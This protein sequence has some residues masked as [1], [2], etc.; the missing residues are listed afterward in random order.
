[1]W[2]TYY[3]SRTT[4]P[5]WLLD[6]I[7]VFTTKWHPCTWRTNR[8]R[9]R[10]CMNQHSN[11][12]IKPRLIDRS[13]NNWYLLWCSHGNRGNYTSA[14]WRM[15]KIMG[16]YNWVRLIDTKSSVCPS[17]ING[18][19]PFFDLLIFNKRES[20]LLTLTYKKIA[21]LQR[22][23]KSPVGRSGDN[24][25]MSD[26]SHVCNPSTHNN[27][28]NL[29][30]FSVLHVKLCNF[31][32]FWMHPTMQPNYRM[33]PYTVNMPLYYIFSFIDFLPDLLYIWGVLPACLSK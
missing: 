4:M 31:D 1:V 32:H 30:Q 8:P 27:Y 29:V 6:H 20:L 10:C 3:P 11:R 19:C 21:W 7:I 2:V 16:P 17:Y 5:Q 18:Q 13:S 24:F 23:I 14:G 33:F 25:L 9:P 12:A 28:H 26:F 22:C 15:S